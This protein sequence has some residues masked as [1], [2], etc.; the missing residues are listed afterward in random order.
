MSTYALLADRV[1]TDEG[2]ASGLCVIVSNGKIVSIMPPA[3]CP[4]DIVQTKLVGDLV[5]GFIDLQVNGGGGVLFNDQPSVDGIR[6]IAEAHRTFG[7]TGLLPTLISDDF[8]T[9]SCAIA[10]VD[11]AIAAGVPGIIGIHL[12]GPF[13][14]ARKKGIHDASKFREL[15]EAALD[16]ISSLKNGKILV[17]LAPELVAH[18]M[19]RELSERA[20]I[21]AA[22]HTSATYEEMAAALACGVSGFT[23]LF[24]AMSAM[25]SRAPGAVGAALSSTS[26]WCS[27]IV[28]GHHVHPAVMRVALAAM[29]AERIIL[30]TDAMPSVGSTSE[31]FDLG[32]QTITAI[33]GKCVAADGTLAGADLNMAQAV[34][35]ACSMMKVPFEKAVRMASANAAAALGISDTCGAIRAGL[36]ANFAL[37]D[38]VGLVSATWID[39]VEYRTADGS[40]T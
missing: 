12:E 29:G 10:A 34:R 26:A 40:I 24:N 5:P 21:I 6:K 33:G 17:T 4:A 8:E 32:G 30:I 31:S 11:E 3:D 2:F 15:D 22:G 7:T 37:L 19:I 9:I 39:G 18:D 14:N 28:D 20:V 25:E 36:R 38:A 27:M 1:L 23:H 13:L 35:N 16:L